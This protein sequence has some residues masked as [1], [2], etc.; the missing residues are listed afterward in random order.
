MKVL[1]TGGA[2]YVGSLLVPALLEKGY[3]VTVLD[4]FIFEPDLFIDF[5][6]NLLTNVKGDIRDKELVRKILKNTDSVIHLAGMSNDPSAI[7]NP[8]VTEDINFKATVDLAKSAKNLGVKRMII[9]S[10]ASVYGIQDSPATEQTI[11]H[12]LTIYS[13]CKLWSEENILPLDDENFTAVAVRPATLSGYAPRMRLDLV[14]NNMTSQAVANKKLKVLGGDQYRP[15]LSVKDM[16][17]VYLNLL[18]LDSKIIGG[19]TYNVSESNLTIKEIANKI[20]L[21][22]KDED[23]EVEMHES[24]DKRSYWVNSDKA[25]KELDFKPKYSVDNSII[26]IVKALTNG[27]IL[28]PDLAKFRN[29]EVLKNLDLNKIVYGFR[30]ESINL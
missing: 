3:E 27:T 22:L 29:V 2:G 20:Q 10:S 18:Q 16:V 25:Q 23:I 26:G 19:E 6:S 21:I 12:P 28:N 9:A 11:P 5:K 1:V 13:K 14:V 30:N 15:N 4:W 24:D 7:I 17:N 8:K